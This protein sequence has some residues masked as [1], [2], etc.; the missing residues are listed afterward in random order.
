[1]TAAEI[2]RHI[3]VPHPLGAITLSVM[4]GSALTAMD[5]GNVMKLS[6]TTITLRYT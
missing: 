5:G 4:F 6:G 3:L 2:I 1:V